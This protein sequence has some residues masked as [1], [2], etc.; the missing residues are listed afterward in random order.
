VY[1]E[2]KRLQITCDL[3]ITR[4]ARG[5]EGH[6]VY[7][8]LMSIGGQNFRF[9]KRYRDFL[10]LDGH[11]RRTYPQLPRLPPKSALRIRAF[12]WF[13]DQREAALENYL[14]VAVWLDE[15]THPTLAD[16]LGAPSV[17]VPEAAAPTRP[18]IRYVPIGRAG[19]NRGRWA[20]FHG[21]SK[22]AQPLVVDGEC[23]KI[24]YDLSLSRSS[25][26]SCRVDDE[27]M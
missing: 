12:R 22:V 10:C 8:I 13:C 2:K 27:N 1:E 6:T 16:F 4:R 11:L 9:W 20:I 17:Q 23:K 5:R 7:E 21:S 14:R 15:L 24:E 25:A 3:C 18:P 26:T 19:S